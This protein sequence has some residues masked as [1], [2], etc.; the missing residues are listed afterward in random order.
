MYMVSD[1][2]V[3]ENGSQTVVCRHHIGHVRNREDRI[4]S[5]AEAGWRLLEE[6]IE[7]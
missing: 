1:V 2:V 5:L 6:Y 3:E 4:A 7:C